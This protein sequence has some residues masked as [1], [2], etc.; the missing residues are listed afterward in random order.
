MLKFDCLYA[1]Q[2]PPKAAIIAPA[3]II[4]AGANVHKRSMRCC[5]PSP[6]LVRQRIDF[7]RRLLR[8][9]DRDAASARYGAGEGV[10]KPHRYRH[11]APVRVSPD[12]APDGGEGEPQR[13]LSSRHLRQPPDLYVRQDPCRDRQ[14]CDRVRERRRVVQPTPS[15]VSLSCRGYTSLSSPPVPNAATPTQVAPTVFPLMPVSPA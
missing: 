13:G 4:I 3:Q 11:R 2:K 14:R 12:G 5:R 8:P 9:T 10:D 15:A 7:R 6:D 1:A